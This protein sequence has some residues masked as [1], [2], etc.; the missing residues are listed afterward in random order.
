MI[1]FEPGRTYKFTACVGMGSNAPSFMA[2]AADR[3]DGDVEF[4]VPLD[5]LSARPKIIDGR[6]TIHVIK[7]GLTYFASAAAPVEIGASFKLLTQIRNTRAN[8]GAMY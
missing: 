8:C 5:L 3:A 1:A 7:D 2:V 6:E 4:V